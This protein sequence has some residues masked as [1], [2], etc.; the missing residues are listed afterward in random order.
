MN[1]LQEKL[2]NKLLHTV[3]DTDVNIELASKECANITEEI[4]CEFYDWVWK[5]VCEEQQSK[6][7]AKQLFQ[8]FLKTL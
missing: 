5:N 8:E 1:K 4:S 3:Y 6:F 2:K 7:T